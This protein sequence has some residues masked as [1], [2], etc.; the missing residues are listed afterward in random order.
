MTG[1][2]AVFVSIKNLSAVLCHVLY[3]KAGAY[4]NNAVQFISETMF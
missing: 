3:N 4:G 1:L 2:N